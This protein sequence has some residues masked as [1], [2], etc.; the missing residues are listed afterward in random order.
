[1]I[2]PTENL[3]NLLIL[4]VFLEKKHGNQRDGCELGFAHETLRCKRDFS[5]RWV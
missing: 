2:Q 4:F 5:V 1:M 3:Y